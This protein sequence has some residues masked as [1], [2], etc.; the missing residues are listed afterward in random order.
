M[1][2][3][4]III[5]FSYSYFPLIYAILPVFA[6]THFFTFIVDLFNYFPIFP[7]SFFVSIAFLSNHH[8]PVFI[9]FTFPSSTSFFPISFL[10]F[11]L[12]HF[13]PHFPFS[14]PSTRQPQFPECYAI[15]SH[16]FQA[17]NFLF[18]WQGAVYSFPLR[19]SRPLLPAAPLSPPNQRC[20]VSDGQTDTHYPHPLFVSCF[21][22]FSL[23]GLQIS[24][25]EKHEKDLTCTL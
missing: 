3:Y 15:F 9:F 1:H 20:R 10:T 25:R 22:S 4:L 14:R 21:V 17:G 12:S 16:F 7:S 13:F 5:Q 19:P 11:F 2:F 6:I 8:H 18:T 24:G 23:T